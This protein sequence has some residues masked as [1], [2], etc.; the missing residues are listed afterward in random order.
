MQ[1]NAVLYAPLG[2]PCYEEISRKMLELAEEPL[3]G[4]N[5]EPSVTSAP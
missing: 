5:G 1:I 3:N 2:A 4:G